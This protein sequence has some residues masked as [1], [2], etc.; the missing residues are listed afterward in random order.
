MK[1][2]VVRLLVGLYP[3]GWRA[4]YG[5][6]FRTLLEEQPATLGGLT[7]IIGC[8]LYERAGL[9]GGKLVKEVKNPSHWFCAREWP[10]WPPAQTFISR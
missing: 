4:R 5:E 7:N 10:R 3:A 8:A 1:P 6:E 9:L 2:Q